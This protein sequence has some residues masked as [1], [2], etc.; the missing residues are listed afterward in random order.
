MAINNAQKRQNHLK[1]LRK[2][3]ESLLDIVQYAE[4]RWKNTVIVSEKLKKECAQCAC[5]QERKTNKQISKQ[6]VQSGISLEDR[7]RTHTKTKGYRHPV[8]VSVL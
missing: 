1:V 8:A 5:P 4:H 7:G 2:I 3:I 6:T